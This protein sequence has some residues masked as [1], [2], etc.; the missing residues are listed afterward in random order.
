M[1]KSAGYELSA[2][3]RAGAY[4]GEPEGYG[5]QADEP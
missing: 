2:R 1:A 4:G 5:P 3:L